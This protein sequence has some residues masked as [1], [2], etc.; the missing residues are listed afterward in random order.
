MSD[1]LGQI[2]MYSRSTIVIS[3]LNVK[4][5]NVYFIIILLIDNKNKYENDKHYV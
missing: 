1:E 5:V 2:S 4:Q 3:T